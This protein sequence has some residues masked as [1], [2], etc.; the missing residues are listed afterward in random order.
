MAQLEI[1]VLVERLELEIPGFHGS[2]E[3]CNNWMA[4]IIKGS[5]QCPCGEISGF[6]QTID[7]PS[8]SSELVESALVES[9]KE[10]LRAH[11]RGEGNEPNF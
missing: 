4:Y 2:W 5:Y 7:T 1:S 3:W 8:V 11:V 10:S 6:R 9:A